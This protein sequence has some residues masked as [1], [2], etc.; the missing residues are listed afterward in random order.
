MYA[1][2]P[3]VG[4]WEGGAPWSQDSNANLPGMV[5]HVSPFV[6][7]SLSDLTGEHFDPKSLVPT[8]D[9]C[10]LRKDKDKCPDPQH[11]DAPSCSV[12]P[13]SHYVKTCKRCI[14]IEYYQ[15]FGLNDDHRA[16]IANHEGDLSIVTVV[17]NP[18]Q[19][20]AGA[21][22]PGAAVGVSHWIHGIEIRYDLTDPGSHCVLQ[23][24]EMVCKGVNAAT[25]NYELIGDNFKTKHLNQIALAQNN[26]LIFHADL[27]N[28]KQQF[29]EHPEVF[30]ELGSHEFWPSRGG[31]S[32]A[33]MIT[34]ATTQNTPISRRIYRI[35]EK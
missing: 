7:D 23:S 33:G 30:P 28:P 12:I 5:A 20:P 16:F 26:I 34:R 1:I 15:F 35:L 4:D 31:T 27:A 32:K 2:H 29:P 21:G 6:P 22:G 3:Y 14:K 9:E 13:P 17:Y 10:A 24:P 11:P 25:T 19:Q 18:D 8:G